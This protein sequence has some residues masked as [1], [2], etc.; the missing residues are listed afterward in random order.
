VAAGC[1]T[2]YH[3][4]AVIRSSSNELGLSSDR[5]SPEKAESA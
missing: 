2:L 3:S 4:G 5:S 1:L